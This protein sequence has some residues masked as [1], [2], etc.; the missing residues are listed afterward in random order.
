MVLLV[1]IV[2]NNSQIIAGGPERSMTL[3]LFKSTS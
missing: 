2:S 3:R 1:V